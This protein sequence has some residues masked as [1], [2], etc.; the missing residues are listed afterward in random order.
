MNWKGRNGPLLIAEIGGNHEGDFE[1]AKRLTQLASSSGVDAVKFQIYTG[2]TIV[3]RVEDPN[4]NKHFK[5]FELSR[6]QYIEL[7]NICQENGVFFTASVWNEE[8]LNWID[9]FI[10]IY[11]IGSGDLTAYPLL[12]RIAKLS[13]PIIISTGLASFEEVQDSVNF[14]RKENIFYEGAKNL[15]VL[16]CTSMYPIRDEDANLNVISHYKNKLDVTVGYS[17]HTEGTKAV[18]VAYVLGAEV[19]EMHFTDEREGKEFRDH[20]VSFTKEEIK[21]FIKKIEQIQSLRG[22]QLKKPLPIEI[23]NN[24][25]T[26][27]RRAVYPSKDIKKGAILSESNLTI[28]RPNKG[29]DARDYSKLIGKKIKKDVKEGQSLDW[30][31]IT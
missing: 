20:K 31:L 11:K 23:D 24:H 27:F 18:E 1:Y 7:A 29:I 30:D 10:P 22:E 14:L 8:A 3:S 4:R 12:K 9:E 13:K 17:D 6:D 2:D 21:I 16:Q 25:L 28:L 19:I 15:A 5:K 26:S